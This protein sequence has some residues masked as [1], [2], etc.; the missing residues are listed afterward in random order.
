MNSLG[1]SPSEED[2]STVISKI[3]ID[4]K[5]SR[6]TVHYSNE[7]CL[8]NGSVDF[9]EFLTMMRKRRSAGE[10]DTELQQVFN[11]TS[12][13]SSTEA[14][15][16]SSFQIFDKNKDGFIDHNELHDMLARL[17]ERL[18]EVSGSVAGWSSLND[19]LPSPLSLIVGRCEGYDWRSWLSWSWWQSLLWRIQSHFTPEVTFWTWDWTETILSGDGKTRQ[20]KQVNIAIVAFLLLFFYLPVTQAWLLSSASPFL[21]LCISALIFVAKAEPLE[22]KSHRRAVLY[23][24][25]YVC[26]L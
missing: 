9:D 2:I 17:G 8:G 14:L 18:T 20:R 7:C 6:W 24:C 16:N 26:N 3:D 19:R 12:L 11:V 21:F 15:V 25:M 22:K 4:G 1:Y 23:V 13:G 10:I 5:T